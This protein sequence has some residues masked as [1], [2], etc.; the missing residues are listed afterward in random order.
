MTAKQERTPAQS[1]LP[2]SKVALKDDTGAKKSNPAIIT[3]QDWI[4]CEPAKA[5]PLTQERQKKVTRLLLG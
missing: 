2:A 5:P 3:T 4:Q 1:Q